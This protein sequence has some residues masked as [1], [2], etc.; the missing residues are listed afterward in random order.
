VKNNCIQCDIF[1]AHILGPS[2]WSITNVSLSLSIILEFELRLLHLLQALYYL[3]HVYSPFCSS[4]FGDGVPGQPDQDLFLPQ[5]GW[6]AHATKLLSI[7]IGSLI[8][9]APAGLELWS[10][11]SQPPVQL[12]VTSV[13]YCSQL[14]VEISLSKFLPMLAWSRGSPNLSLPKQLGLQVCTTGTWLKC[15]LNRDEEKA[16]KLFPNSYSASMF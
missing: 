3:N 15:F 7:K 2:K 9:F 11:C 16:R 1:K 5:L 10:F 8:L 14:L 12:E 13:H 4:Y 6:Q